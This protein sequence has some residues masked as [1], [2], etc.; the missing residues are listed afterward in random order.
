LSF[1]YIGFVV[2][3]AGMVL[4]PSRVATTDFYATS[5]QIIPVLLLVLAIEA[6]VFEAPMLWDVPG[7]RKWQSI[8]LFMNAIT[9]MFY[10]LVAEA[11]ALYP[12]ATG[13]QYA[14]QPRPVVA[15]LAV[16]F[17]MVAV[18]ALFRARPTR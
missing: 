16:G 1:V 6:R 7:L 5:A 15:G 12:L 17:V 18:I 8:A 4:A 14:G 9:M 11:A 13:K 10:L 3:V 2:W